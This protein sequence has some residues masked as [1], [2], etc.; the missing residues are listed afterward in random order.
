[1]TSFKIGIK[2]I[3]PLLMHSTRSLVDTGNSR[4][5][6]PTPEQEAELGLYYNS[7]NKI[8]VPVESIMGSIRDAARDFRVPGKG[9]KTYKNYV[10][11]GIRIPTPPVISPQEWSVDSRPVRIKNSRIIRSRPKWDNW[12]LEFQVDLLD[13]EIWLDP[14]DKVYSG[15]SRLFDIISAAGR[16]KGIGDFRPLYGRFEVRKFEKM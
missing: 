2:G 11:S 10:L 16:F 13:S 14:F 1:M 5:G 15:G 4:G 8:V 12:D 6:K 9:A 3:S 7:D